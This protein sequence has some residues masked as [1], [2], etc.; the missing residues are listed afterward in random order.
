MS[1]SELIRRRRSVFPKFYIP[2]QP[3]DRA[4]IESLLEDANWAPTHKLTEPWRFRIFHSEESRRALS[5]YF[6]DYY[7]KTTPA[8]LYSDEKMRKAGEN[9]LRAGAVIA[10]C[11]RRDPLANLPE[12]EEIASVAMAVQNMYLTCTELQLGCFWSSPK[13][14]LNAGEFL[15]LEPEERCLGLFYLAW[16]NMPDIPGIRKPVSEK[17]TWM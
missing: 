4:I 5:E 11:M 16:H 10:I 8:D 13:A 15:R 1:V 17:T 7:T 14:I 3:I 12:F 9:A 2:G 6:S